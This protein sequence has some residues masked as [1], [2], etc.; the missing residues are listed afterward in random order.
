MLLPPLMFMSIMFYRFR[1]LRIDGHVSWDKWQSILGYRFI[2]SFLLNH[3][4][5]I[6]LRKLGTVAPVVTPV[7]RLSRIVMN[8]SVLAV[9]MVSPGISWTMVTA[10]RP[11]SAADWHV[12]RRA[13][14]RCWSSTLFIYIASRVA[15]P[16]SSISPLW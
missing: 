13:V 12:R 10:T 9:S 5:S 7:A 14:N 16:E 4:L 2:Q 15:M 1:Y 11:T 6:A 3:A 8:G